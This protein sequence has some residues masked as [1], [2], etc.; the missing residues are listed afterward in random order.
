MFNL[1]GFHQHCASGNLGMIKQFE[2]IPGL[3]DSIEE[4][5]KGK[6][7]NG[8]FWSVI[9][10]EFEVAKYLIE[11]KI[12][13]VN[14]LIC[15]EIHILHILATIG[16]RDNEV[17]KNMNQY[18]IL[19]DSYFKN[20]DYAPMIF[21]DEEIICIENY[22]KKKVLEFTKYVI[23]NCDVNMSVQT[24]KKWWVLEQSQAA[25]WIDFYRTTISQLA[26]DLNISYNRYNFTPFHLACLFGYKEMVQMFVE[27]GCDI[28]CMKCKSICKECPY[29][30]KVFLERNNEVDMLLDLYFEIGYIEQELIAMDEKET[31]FEI[32]EIADYLHNEVFWILFEEQR[33][34]K[35][36][37]LQYEIIEMISDKIYDG[38][39][40]FKNL[41]YLPKNIL[42]DILKFIDFKYFSVNYSE[43]DY[44]VNKRK[45]DFNH[46]IYS[47]YYT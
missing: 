46:H 42:E 40:D 38:T 45:C 28:L 43:D 10:G 6:I 9:F 37:S 16:G 35:F 31:T 2:D 20:K 27:Y 23:E 24:Q 44:A 22:D 17:S 3:Y 5:K 21:D 33:L 8:L 1:E 4:E 19:F 14:K 7:V 34:I 30:M 18:Y 32:D 15:D 13:D 47:V 36:D 11:E 25:Q 29:V 41:N 12:F 39:Y 26:N